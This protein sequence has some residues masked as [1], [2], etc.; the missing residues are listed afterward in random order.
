MTINLKRIYD[1]PSPDDGLRIL[2]DRLWPRGVKKETAHIDHWLKEVAP[3]NKL[4][5]WFGHDPEKWDEF[6]K[7]YKFELS[8]NQ[9]FHE[10]KK[11]AAESSILTL[12]YGA[13]DN[14]HNQAV[15]LK[16]LLE[17]SI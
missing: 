17:T 10:L 16:K 5:K 14:L 15:V 6:Q 2:V 7:R 13:H 8:K 1:P 12:L 4:R 11:I 9:A 3:T